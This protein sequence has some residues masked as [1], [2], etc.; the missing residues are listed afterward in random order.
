MGCANG[1]ELFG[2]EHFL[3]ETDVKRLGNRI[4]FK[5][6]HRISL[7]YRIEAISYNPVR[8]RRFDICEFEELDLKC[9]ELSDVVIPATT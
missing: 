4:A 3:F 8:T 9:L 1:N 5:L 7:G 2:V 6:G